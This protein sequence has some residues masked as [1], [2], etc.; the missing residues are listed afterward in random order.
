MAAV[1]DFTARTAPLHFRDD[2]ALT[3]L[4][5]LAARGQDQPVLLGKDN[6]YHS[7][8]ASSCTELV[9]PADVNLT[10][11]P[12]TKM[13]ENL[14]SLASCHDTGVAC[15]I[16]T[17]APSPEAMDARLAA[18]I[19]LGIPTGKTTSLALHLLSHDIVRD[20]QHSFSLGPLD[21][22]PIE[23][24]SYPAP[25][26]PCDR[27]DWWV[28]AL[29]WCISD[30]TTISLYAMAEIIKYGGSHFRAVDRGEDST[31]R[32]MMDYMLSRLRTEDPEF[33]NMPLLFMGDTILQAITKSTWLPALDKAFVTPRQAY[34]DLSERLTMWSP[35][36]SLPSKE[37]VIKSR[38]CNL[39]KCASFNLLGVLCAK[40]NSMEAFTEISR[41]SVIT[42]KSGE[43]KP[44][45]IEVLST[46]E[47]FLKSIVTVWKRP[48]VLD[49]DY[50]PDTM[51]SGVITA[52]LHDHEL[53]I[54]GSAAALSRKDLQ[55]AAG[56]TGQAGTA[57]SIS[58]QGY[59][60]D[61]YN[62]LILKL[63]ESAHVT[64]KHELLEL[65][66]AGTDDY[67]TIFDKIMQSG[68][69]I[70]IKFMLDYIKAIPHEAIF[71]WLSNFKEHYVD[72][73]GIR[74]CCDPGTTP[75]PKQSTFGQEIRSTILKNRAAKFQAIDIL[76]DIW[77]PI[78]RHTSNMRLPPPVSDAMI[79]SDG[80]L[81]LI[82]KGLGNKLASLVGHTLVTP[83]RSVTNSFCSGV[84]SLADFLQQGQSLAGSML[85]N[86]R[87]KATAFIKGM[88]KEQGFRYLSFAKS[89]DPAA[90]FPSPYI[91][92]HSNAVTDMNHDLGCLADLQGAAEYQ[93]ALLR[94]AD[95]EKHFEQAL[96]QGGNTSKGHQ[97]NVPKTPQPNAQKSSRQPP[98]ASTKQPRA[99]GA[100]QPANTPAK[101]QRFEITTDPASVDIGK[102]GGSMTF[103]DTAT[104]FGLGSKKVL[105][106]EL[107]AVCACGINDKCWALAFSS[108][109]WPDKL[110]FCNCKG[111]PGHE[112]HKS[113][114]HNF[115]PMQMLR[116]RRLCQK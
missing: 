25:A 1:V 55:A 104:E 113:T 22:Y 61:V 88:V 26:P 2:P 75:T 57:I 79:V 50:S 44:I 111:Q 63:R 109:P 97:N 100:A 23:S 93:P 66:D 33:V 39:L 105:K 89:D 49:K 14:L 96:S 54:Q 27:P 72:W 108:R 74:L 65:K 35:T 9:A 58:S 38:F 116:L 11:T 31:F 45:S 30:E 83:T 94:L 85:E 56:S 95:L 3:Q 20:N 47:A 107:A 32:V 86:H 34:V 36:A 99:K 92:Q 98:P 90:P 106:S 16:G 67:V 15:T 6:P 10:S 91:S 81:L 52:I 76:K 51:L 13:L 5:N 70:Y 87:T 101:A 80:F 43:L 12:W 103:V 82:Y 114:K 24:R 77:N 59:S 64:L 28:E 102:A 60:R 73:A 69:E 42:N 40:T 112:S 62:D 8:F 46:I 19:A 7:M 21:F 48:A 17:H 84:D 53:G 29:P 4:E 18:A 110:E 78:R 68:C 115:T 71:R 41:L 37:S